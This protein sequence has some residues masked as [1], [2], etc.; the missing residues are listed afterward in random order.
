MTL[1]ENQDTPPGLILPNGDINWNCPCL[2]GMAVGPCGVEF[3]EAFSC[4]HYSQEE[5]KGKECL[6]KFADMQ[7]CMK[8]YP[9]L[10]E[11]KKKEEDG[12]EGTKTDEE[13]N[14]EETTIS[15]DEDIDEAVTK[16]E[17]IAESEASSG[18]ADTGKDDKSEPQDVEETKS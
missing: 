4:F 11:E 15:K 13:V 10:Y 14:T 9:E 1:A 5:P 7:Q 18:N 3:R 12:E 2:G 8:Q 16:E 6:E 17:V